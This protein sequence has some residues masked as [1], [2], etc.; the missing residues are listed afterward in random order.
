MKHFKQLIRL[1]ISVL[2]LISCNSDTSDKTK[3]AFPGVWLEE[4][5]ISQLQQGYREGKYT[6]RQVVADYLTRIEAIDNKGPELNSII[7][8]NPEAIQ[9]A[10]ELDKEVAEG[11]TRGP[12]HGVP[13]QK[14]RC[15]IPGVREP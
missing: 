3:T 14:I 11:K 6:V 12:L 1:L 7:Y 15:Q 10:E 4:L 13:T 5:T 9:I 2:F 8:V